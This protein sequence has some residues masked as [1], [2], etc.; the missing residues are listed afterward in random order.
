MAIQNR[1]MMSLELQYLLKTT[2]KIQKLSWRVVS[3]RNVLPSLARGGPEFDPQ[4]SCT[5]WSSRPVRDAASQKL[6][7][8]ELLASHMHVYLCGYMH[9]HVCARVCEKTQSAGSEVA[10]R[11][12]LVSME[13]RVPHTPSLYSCTELRV[14]FQSH[15]L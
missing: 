6:R 11:R 9:K 4:N 7:E 13:M 1:S 8:R 3:G 10:E 15:R 2:C 5:C 12:P 14:T